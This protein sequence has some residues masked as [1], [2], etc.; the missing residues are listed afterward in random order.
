[1]RGLRSITR[2]EIL[3]AV[4]EIWAVPL[5]PSIYRGHTIFERTP[6]FAHPYS[7]FAPP[8]FAMSFLRSPYNGSRKSSV[9]EPT[10]AI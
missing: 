2:R 4:S 8:F 6:R 9:F 5:R 7:L 10:P 3:G 1:V